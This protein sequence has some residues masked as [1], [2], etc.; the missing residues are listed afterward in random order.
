[1]GA[2]SEIPRLA[3]CELRARVSEVRGQDE[4]HTRAWKALSSKQRDLRKQIDELVEQLSQREPTAEDVEEVCTTAQIM[5]MCAAPSGW[6]HIEE[7]LM[8]WLEPVRKAADERAAEALLAETQKAG[9]KVLLTAAEEAAARAAKAAAA[10]GQPQRLVR[11]VGNRKADWA[12]VTRVEYAE[13]AAEEDEEWEEQLLIAQNGESFLS[14]EADRMV[15]T[16]AE[17]HEDEGDHLPLT[18]V[19]DIGWPDEATIEMLNEHDDLWQLDVVHREQLAWLWLHKKF[20]GLYAKLAELCERYEKLCR[21]K[22]QLDTHLYLTALKSAK[23]VGMTSTA[24]ARHAALASALAAEVVVVEEAAELLESS[25]LVALGPRTKQLLLVGD[26]QQLR[27]RTAVTRLV[28]QFRMPVTM[29]ER[30]LHCKVECASLH[31]QHR[32]RPP[33]SRLIAPIYPS[34]TDHQM[35]RQLTGVPGV[36]RTVYLLKH[37]KPEAIEP[38]TRSRCNP[39]EASFAAGLAAFLLRQGCQPHHVA[40]LTPY[41]GQLLT[42]RRELRSLAATTHGAAD[43]RTS[44]ID[45]F[46]GEQSEVVILTLVRSQPVGDVSAWEIGALGSETRMALMLTRARRGLYIVGNAE[47]LAAENSL[48]QA[49]VRV[50]KEGDAAGSFLQLMATRTETGKRALVRSGDDF[51]GVIGEPELRRQQQQQQAE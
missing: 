18:R 11:A 27:P 1:M 29:F 39:H 31:Q 30:L 22:T 6:L 42:V 43:V 49:L 37:T 24:L 4:E 38:T 48:W 50:L 32:M 19:D 13:A 41:C 44:T 46:R 40:I 17:L 2:P 9:S 14:V 33:L 36:E 25:L 15:D 26:R 28:K 20:E 12:A 21:D 51:E 34:I 10:A 23:V 3:P 47:T 8:T 16:G 7:A 35:T 45:A 5:S